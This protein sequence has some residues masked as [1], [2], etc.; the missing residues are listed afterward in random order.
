MIRRIERHNQAFSG[1]GRRWRRLVNENLDS[2]LY[3]AALVFTGLG[4]FKPG[5]KG[6]SLRYFALFWTCFCAGFRAWVD[7]EAFCFFCFRLTTCEG[8][9]DWGLL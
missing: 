7:F 9:L 6:S 2:S 4:C 1:F 3:S 8:P 5:L